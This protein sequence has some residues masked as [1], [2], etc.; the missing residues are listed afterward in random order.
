[1]LMMI[2]CNFAMIP[3]SSSAQQRVYFFLV[4]C[5]NTHQILDFFSAAADPFQSESPTRGGGVE[6][7]IIN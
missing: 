4:Q 2:E 6:K 1:M 3:F 7:A 5:K